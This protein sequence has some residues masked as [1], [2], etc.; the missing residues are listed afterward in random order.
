MASSNP[1]P[2]TTPSSPQPQPQ[3]QPADSCKVRA[4]HTYPLDRRSDP[5]AHYPDD[6]AE[7]RLHGLAVAPVPPNEGGGLL[8]AMELR[9]VSPAAPATNGGN[10]GE[11]ENGGRG[12]GSP[13]HGVEG[14]AAAAAVPVGIPEVPVPK[15]YKRLR[16]FLMCCVTWSATLQS[17]LGPFFPIHMRERFNASA[18]LIGG[19]FAALSI[20]QSIVG[21]FIASISHRIGRANTLRLGIL[22]CVTGGLIF[23]IDQ[24]W[25]FY[26]SRILQVR[27]SFNFFSAR[28]M[29][30]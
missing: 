2:T 19:V 26:L 5:M 23:S 9:L 18:I 6:E 7:E 15:S 30:N 12:G 17:C 24:I 22:I 21:P 10:N 14:A 8:G 3:P 29:V 25:A 1:T 27:R 28:S 13:K 11:G 20:S 4:P 16:A